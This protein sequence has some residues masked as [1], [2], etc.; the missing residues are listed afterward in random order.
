VVKLISF[1]SFDF[2]CYKKIFLGQQID[3][4]GAFILADSALTSDHLHSLF[5]DS[6]TYIVQ[7]L[8]IILPYI[9]PQWTRLLKQRCLKNIQIDDLSKEINEDSTFGDRFYER[10][11][12]ILNKDTVNFDIYTKL[13]PRESS[14]TSKNKEV[15]E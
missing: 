6:S 14:G 3:S 12:Q 2:I 11:V 1:V 4:N 5:D 9:S 13:I 15:L 10:F 8:Q 7:D